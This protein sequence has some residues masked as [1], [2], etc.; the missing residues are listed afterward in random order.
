M[1]LAE[2]YVPKCDFWFYKGIADYHQ[3]FLEPDNVTSVSEFS[4]DE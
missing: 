1:T 3:S 4:S 2:H